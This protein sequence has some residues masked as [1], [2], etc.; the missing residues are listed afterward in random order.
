V[1][2]V[3]P[4]SRDRTTVLG[5]PTHVDR[6]RG[7]RQARIAPNS[8]PVLNRSAGAPAGNPRI[9]GAPA[10][11]DRALERDLGHREHVVARTPALVAGSGRSSLS[12][13]HERHPAPSVEPTACERSP[14]TRGNDLMDAIS[15]AH[16][17]NPYGCAP[18][19]R[20]VLARLAH[21][22][23]HRYPRSFYDD[24]PSPLIAW[25]A[26]DFAV[27]PSLVALALGAGEILKLAMH[28]YLRPGETVA[29]PGV[30]WPQYHVWAS[31]ARARTVGY[32]LVEIP[33]EA[34]A[35]GVATFAV[36]V[37]ALLRLRTQVPVRVLLL[38]SPNN[39]TGDVFP[40]ER[41]DEV[42]HA[43]R[44][45]VVILD[46]AYAGCGDVHPDETAMPGLT[47]RHPNLMRV[48]TCSKADGL[49]AL[50]IGY[51]VLGAGLADFAEFTSRYLGFPEFL[52]EAAVAALDDLDHRERVRV[53][54][55]GEREQMYRALAPFDQ[56]AVYRSHGNFTF[57][58]FSP[59]VVAP[60]CDALRTARIRFKWLTDPDCCARVSLGRPDENA[61]VRSVLVDTLSRLSAPNGPPATAAAEVGHAGAKAALALAGTTLSEEHR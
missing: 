48:R 46:E 51:A 24:C 56:A 40:A 39:P 2:R 12:F 6:A 34:G 19:V 47:D 53:G 60:V 36:D 9:T 7:R 52:E 44:D 10:W 57:V 58:R 17:T 15:L 4:S 8:S 50:R 3:S 33:P 5:H 49:A 31:W 43:Y 18:G 14:S 54:M 28:L 42:L 30:A 16:N 1:A 38:A 29:L 41:L 13:H 35:G 25:V 55:V 59:D 32:P 22:D 27:D 23:L 11:L 20:D 37:D 21:G 45:A 26:R 61:A